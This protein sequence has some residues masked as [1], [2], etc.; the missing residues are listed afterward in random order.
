MNREA[1]VCAS[2]GG[3]TKEGRCLVQRESVVLKSRLTLI[4]RCVTQNL[5]VEVTK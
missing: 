4:N 2:C 5:S 3:K 1:P